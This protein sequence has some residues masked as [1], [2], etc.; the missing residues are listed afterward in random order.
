MYVFEIRNKREYRKLM[1]EPSMVGRLLEHIYAVAASK[2][3][4]FTGRSSVTW[5]FRTDP[6]R[7]LPGP[8]KLLEVPS[9]S[10][11]SDSSSEFH[12]RQTLTNER[13]AIDQLPKGA[14]LACRLLLTWMHDAD[15]KNK[16]KTGM[17]IGRLVL[18]RA[19]VIFFSIKTLY[20]TK[21]QR[22]EEASCE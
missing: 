9:H 19:W 18:L 6:I 17:R 8:I 2:A 15:G 11:P 20:W 14:P 12:Q 16:P 5:P 10:K 1:S 7:T 3:T 4:Q 22:Q 13:V 21:N